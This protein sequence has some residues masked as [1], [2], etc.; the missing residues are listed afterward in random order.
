MDSALDFG[1]KRLETSNVFESWL[2]RLLARDVS[3]PEF[4]VHV[5][6]V[7]R[8][9]NGDQTVAPSGHQRPVMPRWPGGQVPDN[10]PASAHPRGALISAGTAEIKPS[11]AEKFVCNKLSRKQSSALMRSILN[12]LRRWKELK[13]RPN[14]RPRLAVSVGIRSHMAWHGRSPT[15]RYP[16]AAGDASDP[17]LAL[18]RLAPAHHCPPS[19]LH[20]AAAKSHP[21]ASVLLFSTQRDRWDLEILIPAQDNPPPPP[22]NALSCS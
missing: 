18:R 1:F 22:L 8:R 17:T 11:T 6:M 21:A 10:S 7:G 19:H 3:R 15:A 5:S 4:R 9:P 12:V 14:D 2:V 13:E 20:S 16:I